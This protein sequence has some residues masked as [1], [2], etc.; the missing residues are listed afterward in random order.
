MAGL[1]VVGAHA[2]DAELMAG[3]VAAGAAAA[4][5]DVVLLHLTRGERGHPW[6]DSAEFSVQLENEMQA[7]AEALGV[8]CEWPG[9]VAPL[10]VD[11]AEEAVSE[12]LE[13]LRPDVVI[14]HWRGSW[15]PSHVKAHEAVVV[16]LRDSRAA[17]LFGE[18]CED[19]TGFRVDT[20]V[21]V[22]DVYERWLTALRS[23]ELF[24]LSEPGRGEVSD[25]VMPYWAY[26][27]A[28]ARVRGLQAGVERAQALM[29]GQ[30]AA[31]P[32]LGLRARREAP[33]GTRG[34]SGSTSSSLL[35][36]GEE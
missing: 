3:G 23:Y 36:F 21:P 22:Q 13:R 7:A 14:T 12:A 35:S 20:F 2:L 11:A 16:A 8:R 15:H 32:E 4:G 6:K 10:E 17:L 18:N 29:V 5:F 26:Y 27:T 33:S 30:G 31:P 34:S 9:I 25:Q 28:A 1:L 19:L 24:R